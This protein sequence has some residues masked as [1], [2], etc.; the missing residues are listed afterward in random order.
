M[1]TAGLMLPALADDDENEGLEH[2]Q[3]PQV[4]NKN[5]KAEC[6]S[7]HISL[8]AGVAAGALV[9]EMMPGAG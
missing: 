6:A 7:C 3:L 2:L 9:A 8:P 1:L 5:W 4:S